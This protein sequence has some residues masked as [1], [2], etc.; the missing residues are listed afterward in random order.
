MTTDVAEQQWSRTLRRRG[1]IITA[2]FALLW[3]LLALGALPTGAVVAVS[4]VA[5]LITAAVLF[6]ALRPA[7]GRLVE[8]PR[9]QPEGW[10]RRVGQVNGAEVAGIIVT[11]V[12]A[13]RLGAP[14]WI[15]PVV[16]LIVGLHFF[17]LAGLFDEP[18]Y[19]WTGAGLCVAGVAGL[20]LL[21]LGA[22]A[23]PLVVGLLAAATLWGTSVRLS[24]TTAR[25]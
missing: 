2:L 17:P 12:V 15:A 21:A 11:V 4:A 6:L 3:V 5:V 20:L 23:A 16:C 1:S 24:L 18:V 19:R 13:G 25:P 22:A 9:N 10:L 7:A 8:R 14:Q